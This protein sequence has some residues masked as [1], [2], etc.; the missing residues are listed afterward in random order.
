MK[1]RLYLRNRGD[2][3][4]FLESRTTNSASVIASLNPTHF[5]ES[6]LSLKNC[7]AIENGYDL[8]ELAE[9]FIRDVF[10]DKNIEIDL[11]NGIVISFI[12]GFQKALEIL[13]DKK[14]SE[15]ALYDPIML[16][17]A[18]EDTGIQGINNFSELKEL[19]V[20]RNIKT[21][22]EVIIEM[23]VINHGTGEDGK[24]IET[25]E[26]KLDQNG[27]LILKRL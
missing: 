27:C 12:K 1:E 9:D 11:S 17:V 14:F 6:K 15:E 20:R 7:Q 5:A 2:M 25:V 23:E 18:Y 24:L 16:G 8:D 13:G 19:A 22:W 4:Y 26:P 21:E 10:D 3:D